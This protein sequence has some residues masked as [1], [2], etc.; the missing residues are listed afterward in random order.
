[1]KVKLTYEGFDP[2]VDEVIR[3]ALR[4]VGFSWYAQGFDLETNVRDICFDYSVDPQEPNS[5]E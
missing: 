5:E 3:E 4:G 1:M 2:D